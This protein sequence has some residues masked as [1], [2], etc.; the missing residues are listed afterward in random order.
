MAGTAT[1]LR[2]PPPVVAIL[3]PT[4]AGKSAL[5]LALAEILGGEILCCDSAQ[6][7]RGMDIGTAKA[8]P[9]E[10]AAVPHHLLDLVAPDGVFH[11]AAWAQAA[12]VCIEEVLLRGRLPIIVG[13]TGLYFR[14]LVK[15]LFAAPKPDPAIRARH[16]AE[17]RMLGVAALQDRL[18]AIDPEAA[19][20]ILPGDLVRTSRALEVYEQTGTTISALR[21]SQAE[22]PP[23][24]C[25]FAVLLDYDLDRLRPRI[26]SRVDA[27]LAAG[28][29]DEVRALRAAGYGATR[30]M[31]AL[32]YKQLGQHLDGAL[33]LADAVAAVKSATVAYARRQRTWFRREEIHL[34]A[35]QPLAPVALAG[36][37]SGYFVAQGAR[38]HHPENSG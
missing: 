14:A 21:R 6:V 17:A 12:R 15:G 10:R 29:L 5:A 18:R 28:F 13:G 16:Q 36:L 38:L 34:R 25:L 19:A 24:L 8:T 31:Q 30:A 22:P 33:A 7:Y 20:K 9:A 4:A 32:G 26:G 1:E 2:R 37:L 35:G 3:G 27:M 11:A 23:R